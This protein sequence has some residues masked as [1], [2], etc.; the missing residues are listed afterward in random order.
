MTQKVAIVTGAAVGNIIIFLHFVHLSD[1]FSLA[2]EK[3]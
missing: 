1:L 2:W 3:R